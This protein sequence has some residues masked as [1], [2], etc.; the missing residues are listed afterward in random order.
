MVTEK[1]QQLHNKDLETSL[2]EMRE[3]DIRKLLELLVNEVEL[4]ETRIKKLE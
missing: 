3:N 4:L 1:F 2:K